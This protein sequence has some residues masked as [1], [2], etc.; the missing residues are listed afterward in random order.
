MHGVTFSMDEMTMSSKGSHTE[1]EVWRTK[2]R[3]EDYRSMILFI[4]DTNI[5]Y[6]FVMI[7]WQFV[8]IKGCF[9]FMLEMAPFDTVE[10][11]HHQY[12]MEYLYNLA[13]FFK[14]A[15]NHEKKNWLVVL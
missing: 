6:L 7:M 5:K 9:H 10:G 1:K 11:K 14:A 12:A 3:V 2:N 4:K 8:Y 15:Y 13:N